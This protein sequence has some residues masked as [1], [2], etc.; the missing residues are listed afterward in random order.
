MYG[1][2]LSR[3][4]EVFPNYFYNLSIPR[5]ALIMTHPNSR[6]VAAQRETYNRGLMCPFCR[7]PSDNI[8]GIP[9][10][11]REEDCLIDRAIN[12]YRLRTSRKNNGIRVALLS[13]AVDGIKGSLNLEDFEPAAPGDEEAVA[14]KLEL[15]R[16]EFLR[17]NSQSNSKSKKEKDPYRPLPLGPLVHLSYTRNMILEH[18][19][20]IQQSL[21]ASEQK[22]S[23]LVAQL[24][25]RGSHRL[26]KEAVQSDQAALPSS[27]AKESHESMKDFSQQTEADD[28]LEQREKTDS[29]QQTEST[30]F[31]HSDGSSHALSSGIDVIPATKD[32]S[33]SESNSRSERSESSAEMKERSKD[34]DPENL[35]TE[36]PHLSSDSAG[37]EGHVFP[38]SS[39]EVLET[40]GLEESETP[41]EEAQG[42]SASSSRKSRS[43]ETSASSSSLGLSVSNSNPLSRHALSFITALR[44][45]FVDEPETYR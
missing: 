30:D 29:S 10:C 34:P 13:L 3:L 23:R 4:C 2:V 16:L 43:N 5:K 9:E 27:S 25:Q 37:V 1:G 19:I 39:I 35:K 17:E 20:E 7:R 40:A 11:K 32:A 6:Q 22:N 14:V 28:S 38:E 12:H 18:A 24:K 36:V 41:H 15:A 31:P 21:L 44:D 42:S 8:H 33:F 26:V 45:R